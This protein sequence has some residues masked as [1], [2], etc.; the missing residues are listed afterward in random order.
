[1]GATSKKKPR[2]YV[3]AAGFLPVVYENGT[4]LL[5]PLCSV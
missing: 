1:M 3:Y 2:T 5:E 4:I